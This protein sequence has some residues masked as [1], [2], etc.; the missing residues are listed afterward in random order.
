MI[1]NLIK[2]DGCY[3]LVGTS[4]KG[5]KVDELLIVRY[6]EGDVDTISKDGEN[7]YHA[8]YDLYQTSDALKDGDVFTLDGVAIYKCEGVHV[9]ELTQTKEATQ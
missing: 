4:A 3:H 1:Y 9:I 2:K 5:E 8:L 6:N 7:M